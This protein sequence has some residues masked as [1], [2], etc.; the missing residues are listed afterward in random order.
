MNILFFDT[1]TTG[2]PDWKSPSGEGHQP[3]I[4]QLAAILCDSETREPI[5]TM[6]V[7]VAPDGWEIPPETTEI[8][9]T[10]MEQA[11]AEGVKELA[12]IDQFMG[13]YDRCDI[14]VAHNTTF[15]NRIIRIAL[16][17]YLPDLISDD[18][19][20]NKETYYCTLMKA[21]KIMGGKSGHTLTEAYRHFTGRD[22]EDA[23]TAI[24]DARACMDIY[25]A[26]KELEAE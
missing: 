25:F 16:K 23:H 11:M 17:R 14:R 13:L 24:G 15:D 7:I 1:E 3:H 6:D 5:E 9:G 8:H 12:A 26:I 20:K 19:W 10:S 4:V 22:I 21:R 18:V 2:I